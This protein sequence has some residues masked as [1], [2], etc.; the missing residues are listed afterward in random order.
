MV[1]I[2]IMDKNALGVSLRWLFT[3]IIQSSIDTFMYEL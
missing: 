1:A 3:L 2:K